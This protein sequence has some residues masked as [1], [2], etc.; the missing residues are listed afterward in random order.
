MSAMRGT[1]GDELARGA[2]NSVQRALNWSMERRE[3]PRI[4]EAF[5]WL[6]RSI[7]DFDVPDPMGLGRSMERCSNRDCIGHTPHP[8][9]RQSLG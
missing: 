5:C 4:H 6:C 8:M 3:K 1:A 7:L 2:S 9:T